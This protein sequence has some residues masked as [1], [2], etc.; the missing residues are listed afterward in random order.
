MLIIN[1]RNRSKSV[2]TSTPTLLNMYTLKIFSKINIKYDNKLN[3]KKT[4]RKSYFVISRFNEVNRLF[5][6]LLKIPIHTP[7]N[8]K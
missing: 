2:A 4:L 7:I 5:F 3:I 6:T 8:K 1:E